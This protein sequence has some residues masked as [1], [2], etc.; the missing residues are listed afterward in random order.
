MMDLVTQKK[1]SKLEESVKNSEK[2]I[3]FFKDKFE[4]N[5]IELHKSR[6]KVLIACERL[7]SC[8]YLFGELVKGRTLHANDVNPLCNKIKKFLN[9]DEVLKI[10]KQIKSY[11]A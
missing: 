6:A 8:L 7:N 11:E 5:N 9:D 3:S 2:T 4:F 1:L 10:R